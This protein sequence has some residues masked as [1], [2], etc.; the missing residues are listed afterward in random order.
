MA[1]MEFLLT[2]LSKQSQV[3]PLNSMDV[4]LGRFMPRQCVHYK[5]LAYEYT[6][7]YVRHTMWGAK[8][9]IIELR[10][11]HANLKQ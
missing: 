3:Q 5:H 9:S 6:L 1:A 10:L 8:S 11:L 2:T 7:C 4:Q